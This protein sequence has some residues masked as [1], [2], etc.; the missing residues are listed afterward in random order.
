MIAFTTGPA[1]A[2]IVTEDGSLHIELGPCF[3]DE[4]VERTVAAVRAVAEALQAK[5][6]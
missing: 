4:D 3:T 5:P 1:F 2:V 6:N